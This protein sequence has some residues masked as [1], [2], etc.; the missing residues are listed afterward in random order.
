MS[1][2][3]EVKEYV[4]ARQVAEH[5]GLKVSNKGMACC[6]FHDD[7][8]PSMKL[9]S[10]YYCFACGARGDAINY[11]AQMFGLSQ[12]EAALKITED[13][14]LPIDISRGNKAERNKKSRMRKKEKQEK[15]K[16]EHI[17]DRF[18]RWCRQ[19]TDDLLKCSKDI[20]AVKET[21]K[22]RDPEE[23]FNSPVYSCVLYAEPYIGNWLDILCLGTDE[24]R[25][26][27]FMKEREGVERIAGKVGNAVRG[28]LEA[29]RGDPG[30]GNEQCG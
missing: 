5:Y 3:E 8:H 4:T 12:Y 14:S 6:P 19:K 15:A 7:H 23:V 28:I 11:A 25:Q 20:A 13:L 17:R 30:L 18:N 26:Q 27:L 1:I 22:D 16:V 9:D 2:F 24:E 21:F 29:D 10:R